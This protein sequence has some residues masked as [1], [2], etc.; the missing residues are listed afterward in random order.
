[1]SPRLTLT[2]TFGKFVAVGEVRMRPDCLIYPYS[3]RV[4][5]EKDVD[6]ARAAAFVVC[7]INESADPFEL[8]DDGFLALSIDHDAKLVHD[9]LAECATGMLYASERTHCFSLFTFGTSARIIRWDHS[10]AIVSQKFSLT[11]RPELLAGFFRGL[12]GADRAAQGFDETV[13]GL[14]TQSP[15]VDAIRRN[16]L[17]CARKIGL[18]KSALHHLQVWEDEA[19]EWVRFEVPD[20]DDP[21]NTIVCSCPARPAFC[22]NS[23]FGRGTK[24]WVVWNSKTQSL[25]WYKRSWR[26]DD[27]EFVPEGETYAALRKAGV[28]HVLTVLGHG[29]IGVKETE[30]ERHTTISAQLISSCPSWLNPRIRARLDRQRHYGLLLQEVGVAITAFPDIQVAVRALYDSARGTFLIVF[31]RKSV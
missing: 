9:R 27:G 21:Q 18:T 11:E 30:V 22:S 12:G 28:P 14:G 13:H 3:A 16:G 23:L 29:D 31:L 7:K 19:E 2:N 4:N 8:D 6:V 15:D 26:I 5:A 24:G 10:V 1:M 20:V 17:E 25:A